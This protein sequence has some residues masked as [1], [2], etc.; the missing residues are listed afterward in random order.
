M[1]EVQVFEV[2]FHEDVG[3]LEVE[4]VV[5]GVASLGVV[6]E[7]FVAVVVGGLELGGVEVG[8]VEG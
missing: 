6:G 1:D 2:A 8:V 5:G 3:V 7:V 4:S